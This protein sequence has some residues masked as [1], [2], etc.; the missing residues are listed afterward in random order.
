MW[1]IGCWSYDCHNMKDGIGTSPLSSVCDKK[2]T[3]SIF[4]RQAVSTVWNSSRSRALPRSVCQNVTT[5]KTTHFF[6]QRFSI[7][8]W[9]CFVYLL[10]FFMWF[11]KQMPITN[12]NWKTVMSDRIFHLRNFLVE[13]KQIFYWVMYINFLRTNAIWL[14]SIKNS[15]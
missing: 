3:A 12:Y 1:M 11:L 5:H 13:K 4:R 8:C 2:E 6:Q 9:R 7:L 10:L 14:M 15:P